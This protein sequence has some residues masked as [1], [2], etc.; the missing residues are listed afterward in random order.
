MGN[1]ASEAEIVESAEPASTVETAT[2]VAAVPPAESEG[3][4]KEQTRQ[5]PES[6]AP[7]GVQ[8]R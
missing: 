3:T 6:V 2:P 1:P 8:T 7:K 5:T 4:L